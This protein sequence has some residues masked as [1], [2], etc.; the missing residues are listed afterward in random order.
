MPAFS[1]PQLL[2]SHCQESWSLHPWRLH[3]L[4][5]ADEDWWPCGCFA[6]R[7]CKHVCS[8]VFHCHHQP[9]CGHR[10]AQKMKHVA[11]GKTLQWNNRLCARFHLKQNISFLWP[12]WP[13]HR[14]GKK[15]LVRARPYTTC[16]YMTT[17]RNYEVDLFRKCEY[18]KQVTTISVCK[19]SAPKNINGSHTYISST[20]V[21]SNEFWL[22]L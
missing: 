17:V 5:T 2:I 14:C 19:I 18:N 9:L 7:T 15:P 16:N 12:L 22:S 20:C 21:S 8:F 13:F 11:F 4:G 10:T 1:P 3:L 6:T